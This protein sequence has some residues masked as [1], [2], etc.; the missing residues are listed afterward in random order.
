M[1]WVVQFLDG[2]ILIEQKNSNTNYHKLSID[3]FLTEKG[4]Q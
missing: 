1:V 2:Y 3:S 4:H